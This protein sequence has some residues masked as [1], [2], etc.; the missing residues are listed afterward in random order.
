MSSTPNTRKHTTDAALLTFLVLLCAGMAHAQK[1]Q[2]KAR[3]QSDEDRVV[4]TTNLVQ[5]DAVVTDKNGKQ[6]TN[7]RPDD[8]ELWEDGRIRDIVGFSY[9]PLTSN[10]EGAAS[11]NA[12]R[13]AKPPRLHALRPES[14]RRA[15]A[16]LVDDFG[17]SFESIARTRNALEKFV[18]EQTEPTD[19]IAVV[20]SSSGPG[21]MQQFTANRSELLTTIKSIR[22]YPTGRGGMSALETID[23]FNH[24]EN[25]VDLQ[26]YSSGTPPDLSHKEFFGGSLG[27]L[28]FVL[29]R[30]A[31][32]P[33]RKSIVLVSENLPL[34]SRDALVSGAT[35]A[36]DKLIRFA[37]Q[38]S[39]VISAIDARG[40][41]KSGLTADDSQYNLAANQVDKILRERGARFN[42]AQDTLSYL[43]EKTGGVFVRNN[44]DLNN[45][46]RRIIDSEQ[47][48]YLMAYRPDDAEK[49]RPERTYKV[50]LKLK[51]PEL[52]LRSRSDFHRFVSNPADAPKETKDDV[53]RDA[54]A[55]P[56]VNEDIRLKVTVLSTG[57]SQLKVLVH[58]DARDITLT[59]SPQGF[60]QGSFD[61]AVVAFDNNGKVSQ[62][63]VRTEPVSVPSGR[64]EQILSEGLVYTISLPM[65]KPA[66]YQVRVAVRDDQSGRLGSDS[67]SVE[68]PEARTSR[69]SVA[70][71][72]MQAVTSGKITGGPAIRRFARGD[73]LEYSYLVYGARLDAHNST[74]L[75]TQICLFRASDKVFT[76]PVERVARAKDA[77]SEAIIVGGRFT[78]PES[79]PPGEYFLQVIV[80]DELAPPE[81]Q[82]SIQWIDF[83]IAK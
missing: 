74:D 70:G 11:A 33:G 18:A 6:V 39:I 4:V 45:G 44:N 46:L 48:Y 67:Q 78:L 10:A 56:F 41:P 34:T 23:P 80:T 32:F 55:S 47:G 26:G 16:I 71:L 17:L 12:P 22:W 59:K 30:L 31:R 20:R 52:V 25:G 66:P 19:F 57:R 42:T 82:T 36:L 5:V 53:L 40:L 72:I 81:R 38:H 75:T 2:D 83:E 1:A 51:R 58:L 50:T 65:R 49:E 21:A 8:F 64:Y 15:I 62:E 28:A 35:N 77:N 37:N 29:D 7:L 76:A 43:A 54:L 27:A 79:L 14:V 73:A 24:N 60:Y 68:I 13:A 9:I 61:L 69:L 63:L 3:P